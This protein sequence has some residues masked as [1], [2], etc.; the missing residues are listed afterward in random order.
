MTEPT[1]GSKLEQLI[2]AHQK[3]L[4]ANRSGSHDLPS[5]EEKLWGEVESEIRNERWRKGDT[6]KNGAAQSRE[7]KWNGFGVIIPILVLA[8]TLV[9]SLN[10]AAELEVRFRLLAIGAA[11]VAV[12]SAFARQIAHANSVALDGIGKSL[13]FGAAILALAATIMLFLLGS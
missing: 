7:D 11:A 6:D 12:V 9:L 1:D 4:Q 2:R 5:T 13:G 8:V 3:E 10:P